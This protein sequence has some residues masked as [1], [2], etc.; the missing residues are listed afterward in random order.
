[1]KRWGRLSVCAMTACVLTACGRGDP[2][3]GPG[4]WN[5]GKPEAVSQPGPYRVVLPPTLLKGKY[6]EAEHAEPSQGLA[7]GLSDWIDNPV[8]VFAAYEGPTSTDKN[9]ATDI[10]TVTGVQG[11]VLSP[12]QARTH[13]LDM[14]DRRWEF[15]Q[16][17]VVGPRAITPS[18]GEPLSCRVTKRRHEAG[19]SFISLEPECTW[20]D[21]SAVIAVAGSVDFDTQPASI[22]L[23]TFAATVATVRNEVSKRIAAKP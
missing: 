3:V 11:F 1:M 12:V 19:Q 15:P 10:L 16:E 18:G 21:G 4:G 17:T 20:A 14:L 6:K 8:P 2:S 9:K 7:R 13:M 5:G 22:N 23:D